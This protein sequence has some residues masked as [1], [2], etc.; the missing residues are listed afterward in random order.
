MWNDEVISE[1]AEASE[2][3][4]EI[5]NN[6][7]DISKLEEGKIEFNKNYES[8]YDVLD[9]VLKISRANANKKKILIKA[10][11]NS[12]LPHLL[13]FDKS[14][15]T[16]V[17]MNVVGNAIKFTPENGKI[18]IKVGLNI[19]KTI[20]Q[21]QLIKEE[22]KKR[23][24]E[25]ESEDEMLN[26]PKSGLVMNRNII[27][28]IKSFSQN[29]DY[30]NFG[31]A[32]NE[33]KS[34]LS[35]KE[36]VEGHQLTTHYPLQL[37]DHVRPVTTTNIRQ[38]YYPKGN[39]MKLL[40]SDRQITTSPARRL[41]NVSTTY[42]I[43]SKTQSMMNLKE[44]FDKRPNDM[45]LTNNVHG[46]NNDIR[47][48]K[49]SNEEC[50]ESLIEKKSNCIFSPQQESQ[51][52]LKLREAIKKNYLSEN[53]NPTVISLGSK[54][55]KEKDEEKKEGT[56]VI[57][58]SDTGCGI[59]EAE[60]SKLFKPFSQANK[61]TYSNFGG[62][63]LGLWLSHKLITAMNGTITCSSEVNKGTTFTISLPVRYKKNTLPVLY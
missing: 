47:I 33:T 23:L 45:L 24:S 61:T 28:T 19:K 7:L 51:E 18:I 10:P 6:T 12:K 32:A 21:Y 54:R 58:I 36:K 63:G 31:S 17:I 25:T 37:V 2:L 40:N 59:S 48:I 50:V 53:D 20:T 9:V 29:I 44:S 30:E 60:Q 5:L 43:L 3:L 34:K 57:K 38:L 1:L 13:E 49:E 35:P 27:K 52:R 22:L 8:I 14:R 56:L 62:T 46:K 4:A 16:Q 39:S 15:L 55:M 42:Q 41:I 26:T 11:Y